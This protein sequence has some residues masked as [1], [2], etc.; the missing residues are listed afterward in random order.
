MDCKSICWKR[1]SISRIFSNQ[2]GLFASA[3]LWNVTNTPKIETSWNTGINLVGKP[4]WN[5]R[6]LVVNFDLYYT[7]FQ[8]QLVVDQDE[9]DSRIYIYGLGIKSYALQSIVTLSYPIFD[10]VQLKLV[11]NLLSPKQNLKR[12]FK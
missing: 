5:G 4:Y 7:W 2:S 8:N 6:E 9:S 11:A 1:V 10:R 3:K 12:P